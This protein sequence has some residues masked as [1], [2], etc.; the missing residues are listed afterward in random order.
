MYL[1][2][3]RNVDVVYKLKG[4]LISLFDDDKRPKGLLALDCGMGST[5]T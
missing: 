5:T 4:Y 3:S 1:V 2:G